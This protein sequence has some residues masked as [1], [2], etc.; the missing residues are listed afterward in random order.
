MVGDSISILND[1]ENSGSAMLDENMTS[2]DRRKSNNSFDGVDDGSSNNGDSGSRRSSYTLSPYKK[3]DTSS[4]QSR[5][6]SSRNIFKSCFLEQ[7]TLTSLMK[8]SLNFKAHF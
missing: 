4:N 3:W 7:W 2:P 6:G 8:Q 1:Y 5:P